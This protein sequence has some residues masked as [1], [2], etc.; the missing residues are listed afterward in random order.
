MFGPVDLR[1]AVLTLLMVA[2]LSVQFPVLALGPTWGFI[3]PHEHITRG[4]ISPSAWQEHLRQ[5]RLG[6]SMSERVRCDLPADGQASTVMGSFP[7]TA[8]AVSVFSLAAAHVA[9]ARVEIPA[10]H[11]PDASFQRAALFVLEL[12]YSPPVPPPNL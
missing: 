6:F 10:P 5:H 12:A 8:G 2:W 7:E 11:M 4:A 1:R 3:L 9:D